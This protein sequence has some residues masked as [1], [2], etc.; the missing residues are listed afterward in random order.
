MFLNDATAFIS[1]GMGGFFNAYCMFQYTEGV[2]SYPATTGEKP[3]PCTAFTFT[4]IDDRRAVLFGG[5]DGK[6]RMN[7]VYIIDLH[8]MVCVTIQHYTCIYK[9]MS[10]YCYKGQE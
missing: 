6:G 1:R 3:P 2:W 9:C 5:F 7:D 10:T 8:S 4:A